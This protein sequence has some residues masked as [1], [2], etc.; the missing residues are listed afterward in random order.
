MGVVVE[1]VSIIFKHILKYDIRRAKDARLPL[2]AIILFKFEIFIFVLYHRMQSY[3][4]QSICIQ[5]SIF[6]YT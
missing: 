2:G 4:P 6:I 1:C 5:Y 3:T